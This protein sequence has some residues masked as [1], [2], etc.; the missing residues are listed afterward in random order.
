[1]SDAAEQERAAVVKLPDDALLRMHRELES[2][3]PGAPKPA[4][5]VRPR[6]RP[7]TYVEIWRLEAARGEIK[8][9]GL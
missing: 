2:S 7:W 6:R 3:R 8:R 5:G 1:M 9:R 4:A